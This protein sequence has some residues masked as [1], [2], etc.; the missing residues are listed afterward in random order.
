[1]GI[2][3]IFA[4]STRSRV[5]REDSGGVVKPIWL[6]TMTWIVPPRR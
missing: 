1:M 6:L 5:E 4:T 3:S 2:W